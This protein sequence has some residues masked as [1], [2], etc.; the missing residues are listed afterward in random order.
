MGSKISTQI[1]SSSN[2]HQ[3]IDQY[4]QY[5]SENKKKRAL[6]RN[7]QANNSKNCLSCSLCSG[8]FT[9]KVHR[10]FNFFVYK[11]KFIVLG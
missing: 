2:Q 8:F 10:N 11:R 3:K 5:I 6:N 7:L 9:K 4:I 1:S